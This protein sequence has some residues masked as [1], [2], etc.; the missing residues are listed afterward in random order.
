MN[1]WQSNN[2]T[3]LSLAVF[4][5]DSHCSFTFCLTKSS[6]S[7]SFRFILLIDWICLK[8]NFNESGLCKNSSK[9]RWDFYDNIDGIADGVDDHRPQRD[10]LALNHL[11]L[12]HQLPHGQLTWT[13]GSLQPWTCGRTVRWSTARC[14]V[15]GLSLWREQLQYAS[16][17]EVEANSAI[18]LILE[19][20][21]CVFGMSAC[22]NLVKTSEGCVLPAIL[23]TLRFQFWTRSCMNR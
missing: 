12:V 11:H 20:W 17:C 19:L 4:G 21:R 15:A 9:K 5:L 6:L 22:G 16:C 3:F 1:A 2:V 14:S 10:W 23:V 18:H 8:F 7:I 13:A